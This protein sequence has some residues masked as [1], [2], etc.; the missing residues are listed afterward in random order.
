VKQHDDSTKVSGFWNADRST[1][2]HRGPVV[3]EQGM[4][5]YRSPD[6]ALWYVAS[7]VCL[8]WVGQL[9]RQI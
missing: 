3:A 8:E 4:E 7:P 6:R 2:I 5:G 1:Q 9:A